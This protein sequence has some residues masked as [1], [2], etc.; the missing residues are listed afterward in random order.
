MSTERPI[1]TAQG[2]LAAHR[3]VATVILLQRLAQSNH[4]IVRFRLSETLDLLDVSCVRNA[5]CGNLAG[6]QCHRGVT[7]SHAAQASSC[8]GQGKKRW[9]YSPMQQLLQ[10][11]GCK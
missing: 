1:D 5:L 11:K 9:K 10:V 8:W 7:C 2:T 4:N 3:F 6:I